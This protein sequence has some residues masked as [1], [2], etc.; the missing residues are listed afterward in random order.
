MIKAIG[1]EIVLNTEVNDA[2]RR[3][4]NGPGVQCSMN[5]IT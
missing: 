1:L 3:V 4:E 5:A 2:K